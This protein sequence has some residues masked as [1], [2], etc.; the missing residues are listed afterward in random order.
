MV[1]GFNSLASVPKNGEFWSI[2]MFY[3]RLREEGVSQK[4]WERCSKLLKLKTMR[5]LSDFNDTCNV[6]DVYILGVITE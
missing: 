6:Q 3:S 1:T 4:E 5:N 2:E